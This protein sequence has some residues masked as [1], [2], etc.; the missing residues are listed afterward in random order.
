MG[1]PWTWPIGRPGARS[2]SVTM[3]T[4][5][6]L[7]SSASPMPVIALV[8]PGPGHDAEDADLA[9]GPRRGVGHDAGRGLVGDQEVGLTVGLEGV[10]ELV[11][12]GP[13]DAEDAADLPRTAGAAAAAWA[14]VI[15]PWTP[16]RR[17]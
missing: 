13:R 10:P 16:C 15:R 8:R 6:T 5:G 14:P 3:P 11:V 1:S 4:I 17:T 7:S 12:L 9:G 2:T